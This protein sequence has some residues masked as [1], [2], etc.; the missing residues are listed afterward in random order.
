[1]AVATERL[2]SAEIPKIRRRRQQRFGDFV[3]E[4]SRARVQLLQD[5]LEF[6]TAVRDAER[7]EAGLAKAER[8]LEAGQ[9]RITTLADI[10]RK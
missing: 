5:E 4:F 2:A 10:Y 6:W 7:S 3:Q 8:K 9:Q 1:M